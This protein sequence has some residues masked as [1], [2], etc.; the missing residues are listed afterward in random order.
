MRLDL[1]TSRLTRSTASDVSP[2]TP[3][4]GDGEERPTP[5]AS[6]HPRRR[7]FATPGEGTD[8]RQVYLT[9]RRGAAKL[10]A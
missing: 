2:T 7:L 10:G 5:D 9:E 3:L 4:P 8:I 1:A 6:P